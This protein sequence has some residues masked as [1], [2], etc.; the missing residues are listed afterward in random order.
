MKILADK[1]GEQF[2]YIQE[3]N[4][5][6]ITVQFM[7]NF[8]QKKGKPFKDSL[9]SLLLVGWHYRST[10]NAIGLRKFKQGV[11]DDLE[12]S[13]ALHQT[14]PLGR[15]VKM[16]CG[17]VANIASYANTHHDGYYLYVRINDEIQ[18]HKLTPEWEV[19]PSETLLHLPYFPPP[20]TESELH[21]IS[22]FDAWAGGF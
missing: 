12:V 9:A 3:Q 16:P 13:F 17:T 14:F 6:A 2:L 7:D 18:R 1:H 11:T 15:K 21:T 4:E 22:E 20:L 10:S 8:G 5:D 19:L